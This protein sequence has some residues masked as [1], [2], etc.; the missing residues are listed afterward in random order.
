ME[1]QAPSLLLS[2][3][4]VGGAWHPCMAKVGALLWTLQGV[5]GKTTLDRALA[6]PM[7]SL[8]HQHAFPQPW[9][10]TYSSVSLEVRGVGG[11]WTRGPRF[12]RRGEPDPGPGSSTASVARQRG[13]SDL[14]GLPEGVRNHLCAALRGAG[15]CGAWQAVRPHFA[16]ASQSGSLCQF[17]LRSASDSEGHRDCPDR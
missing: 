3:V 9:A 11:R 7:A 14:P 13:A 2:P 1:G 17:S 16:A 15:R 6:L 8:A 5:V 4:L 10:C 12:Q